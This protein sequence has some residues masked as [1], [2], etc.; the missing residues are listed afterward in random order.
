[1]K[2]V[3]TTVNEGFTTVHVYSNIVRMVLL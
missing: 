3:I 1:M 2:C